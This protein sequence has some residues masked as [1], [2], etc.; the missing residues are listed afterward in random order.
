MHNYTIEDFLQYYNGSWIKCPD[1]VIGSISG[2]PDGRRTIRVARAGKSHVDLTQNE[3]DWHHVAIPPLGYI[4]SIAGG[5]GLYYLV[6][7]VGR[8][9]Q[10]G[11]SDSTVQVQEV[12]AVMS[13]LQA[14]KLN[15]AAYRAGASITAVVAGAA[16]APKF[17]GLEEALTV[18]SKKADA[19]G[20]ALNSDFALVLG[21]QS[22]N[23]FTLLW[24]Q[25]PVA[26][27]ADGRRWKAHSKEYKEIIARSLGELK[28][29]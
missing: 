13:V 27:S 4:N 25:L 9:T 20:F 22:H 8:I 1:G 7:K 6:R 29:V 10:K 26:I 3:L 12:P 15:P 24:Q 19:V 17:V 11:F 18:M 2:T 14:L 23:A 21:Q 5:K 16:Y 28:Y